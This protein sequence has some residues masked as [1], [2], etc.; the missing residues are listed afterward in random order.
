MPTA[1]EGLSDTQIQNI[2]EM[3]DALFN[4]VDRNGDESISKEELEL[5]KAQD[6]RL[7]GLV[8]G[9]L[10]EALSAKEANGRDQADAQETVH[11]VHANRAA[12]CE[13]GVGALAYIQRLAQGEIVNEQATAMG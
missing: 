13:S 2:H 5:C 7:Y 6:G 12:V 10:T 3:S 8:L 9:A 11:K 1:Y 4:I